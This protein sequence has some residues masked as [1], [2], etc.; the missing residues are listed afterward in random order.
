M[1][2]LTLNK[3]PNVCQPYA[4]RDRYDELVPIPNCDAGD[5]HE[6]LPQEGSHI[7]SNVEQ[8][9]LAEHNQK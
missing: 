7:T 9:V 1:K 5:V 4:S 8:D 3:E 6:Q 2:G